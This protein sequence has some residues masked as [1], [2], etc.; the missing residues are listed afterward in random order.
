MLLK[1]D[2]STLCIDID[3][4]ALKMRKEFSATVLGLTGYPPLLAHI[5]KGGE[6]GPL[7]RGPDVNRHRD[8]WRALMKEL[9]AC[10]PTSSEVADQFHTQWHVGHHH[11]RALV[12]DDELLMDMLWKW[13]P[14]YNGPALLLYR[15][16]NFNRFELG[17][18]GTAWSDKE[19]VA[20]MFAGGLNAEGKGGVILETIAPADAI[21][22]GPSAHSIYLGEYEYTVDRRRLST[23]NLKSHFPPRQS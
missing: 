3:L 9:A 14:R 1:D 11:I 16:E 10:A 13:L 21:I 8:E 20:R 18:I 22:A 19:S 4:R 23:I 15:G 7:L 17:K 2:I 6:Y 5:L 12:D